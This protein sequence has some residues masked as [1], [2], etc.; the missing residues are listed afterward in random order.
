VE[1]LQASIG[2]QE[3]HL[4]TMASEYEG[5]QAQL[6]AFPVAEAQQQRQS[7]RQD[8]AT[9]QTIVAGR[10][11]VVDSR[12]A[13]LNQL[14]TQWQRLQQ[15]QA[16]LQAQ[17]AELAQAAATADEQRLSDELAQVEAALQP[18]LAQL[19]GARQG[20]QQLEEETA[21]HQ[22]HL[23]DL[24]TRHTQAQIKL[25]QQESQLEGLQERIKADLGIVA[26]AYDE[27]Q[28]GQTP[29]PIGEVVEQLPQVAVL[30]EDIESTIHHYRG[31]MQR[32]GAI[33]PDAP[34]EYEET[35]TRHDFLEQQ[36]ADLAQTDAQL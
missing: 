29:L 7:L 3:I 31:Q 18:Y 1:E 2:E 34:Q 32:M 14:D 23:H 15:R 25:S 26:L 35:Q 12:R 16:A 17:Q 10:Q 11:A 4:V 20:L 21:V 5:A 19:A 28:T 6:A 22:R 13:T 9:A 27:D 36:V 8:V 30:P 33:N 24:E